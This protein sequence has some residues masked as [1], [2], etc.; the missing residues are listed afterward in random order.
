MAE[1]NWKAKVAG[2]SILAAATPKHH[3]GSAG[4][5]GERKGKV[6]EHLFSL[7]V[8]GVV[9]CLCTCACLCAASLCECI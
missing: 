9:V 3:V 7:R 5:C 2:V 4:K 8:C 6:T 1:D